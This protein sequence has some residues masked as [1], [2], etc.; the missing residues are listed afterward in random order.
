MAIPESN[1]IV[2]GTPSLVLAIEYTKIK[3]TNEN[4]NAMEGIANAPDA[5]LNPRTIDMHA[6]KAAPE[7]IP[8]TD[9]DA[10][11]FLNIPCIAAP[12]T[13]RA[14]PMH[15]AHNT[16]GNRDSNTIFLTS[17][18]PYGPSI[19]RSPKN[20]TLTTSSKDILRYPTEMET[21]IAKTNNINEMTI[22]IS[23]RML[24]L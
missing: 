18:G 17:T 19:Y 3:V 12:E 20:K 10:I 2:M 9:G 13:E 11:G 6:P 21:S 1:N 24:F 7:D 23:F 8:N 16:L 22:T 14:A 4:I 15:I 5:M